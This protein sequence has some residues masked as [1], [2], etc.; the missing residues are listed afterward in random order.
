VERAVKRHVKGVFF[1][2]Y[3]RML[4]AKKQVD[5][6]RELGE[7]D[8]AYLG[9]QIEPARWYPMAAFERLGIAILRGIANGDVEAVRAWGRRSAEQLRSTTPQLVCPEDP[10]ETLMRMRVLRSTYFDFDALEVRTLTDDNAVIATKYH[11][12]DLA[13]EAASYQTLGFFE[14]LVEAAGAR[15]VFARFTQRAW[16]GD[17]QTVFV[18]D[19][20]TQSGSTGEIQGGSRS[21]G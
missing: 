5:W 1:A 12:S 2:E 3:V 7:E 14:R 17:A 16:T 13:E 11:M 18:I 10:A 4:R 21:R 15:R 19:W 20:S 6:S 8:L 9:Q